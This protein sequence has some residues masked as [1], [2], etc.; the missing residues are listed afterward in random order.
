MVL[1]GQRSVSAVLP[2]S[3]GPTMEREIDT[4]EGISILEAVPA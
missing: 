4:A 1:R 3:Q 2:A